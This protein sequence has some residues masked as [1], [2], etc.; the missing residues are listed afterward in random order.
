M[1][2]FFG[3]RMNIPSYYRWLIEQNHEASYAD[4]HEMLKVLGRHFSFDRWMLK[5]PRHLLFLD[6]LL[7]EFPEACII[8][9][10]RDLRK[11]VPSFCSM[12]EL[13]RRGYSDAVESEVQLLGEYVCYFCREMLVRADTVRAK[14]DPRR[15]FDVAYAE[16]VADPAGSIRKIYDYFHLPFTEEMA[17]N[18]DVWLKEHPKN[19]HG[20]HTYALEQYGLTE[21]SIQDYFKD[22]VQRYAIPFE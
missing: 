5:S 10:H 8:W 2:T 11:V 9:P 21:A 20:S 22:Y 16:L 12:V 14:A 1:D 13:M 18:I 7:K 15:F 3:I 6:A 17:E 19:K 4:Y